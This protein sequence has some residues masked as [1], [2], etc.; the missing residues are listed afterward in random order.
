MN[1]A[2]TGAGIAVVALFV[3][4]VLLKREKARKTAGVFM[5]VAGLGLTGGLIGGLLQ[6]L[7]SFVGNLMTN[8]TAQVFGVAVPSALVLAIGVWLYIDFHP[9]NKTPSKPFPVLAFT[10]PVLLPLLGGVY[11][12][13][14]HSAL[15][16]I[17]DSFG[18]FAAVL[19]GSVG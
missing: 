16:A 6:T 3:A 11:A 2:L 13:M 12:G 7:G 10:F 15:T 4:V 8:V 14:G 9:K 1:G 19:V 18:S 5:L 17:G